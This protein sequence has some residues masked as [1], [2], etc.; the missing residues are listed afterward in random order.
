MNETPNTERKI[1]QDPSRIEA[2]VML[3]TAVDQLLT[4]YLQSGGTKLLT[5]HQ[6][7]ALNA[8]FDTFDRDTIQ[9]LR[10]HVGLYVVAEPQ[11]A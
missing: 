3:D 6:R 10:Y 8:V 1:M 2:V 11:A 5:E 7:K 4:A 9:A